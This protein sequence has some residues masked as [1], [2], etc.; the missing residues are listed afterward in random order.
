MIHLYEQL[1]KV[2]DWQH[3]KRL[4]LT[5]KQRYWL[6]GNH[7]LTKQL[8]EYSDNNFELNLL[9]ETWQKPYQHEAEV[10]RVKPEQ[11]CLVREVELLCNKQV[12]VYARSIISPAA[13]EA[14]GHELTKL[15]NV[16]LGHLLFKNAKVDLE[17][18]ELAK[19]IV[20]DKPSFAR[21]TLY[22]LNNE[23]ILVSEFFI[24]PL[25]Q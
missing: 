21:R 24:E 22:Q 2:K 16:P 19:I 20:S 10:L 13:I 5:D 25:W 14:S 8:I 3:R 18:R 12:V 9:G 17:T 1:A 11:E 23:D 4:S 6:R 15:G 7:S